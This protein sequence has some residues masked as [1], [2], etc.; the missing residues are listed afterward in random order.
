MTTLESLS[1]NNRRFTDPLRTFFDV[2]TNAVDLVLSADGAHLYVLESG[3]KEVHHFNVAGATGNLSFTPTDLTLSHTG[4]EL[5]VSHS[6]GDVVSTPVVNASD[7]TLTVM[8]FARVFDAANTVGANGGLNLLDKKGA[9]E[10]LLDG[11]IAVQYAAELLL[12]AGR[13][14]ASRDLLTSYQFGD[15]HQDSAA[16]YPFHDIKSR[17]HSVLVLTGGGHIAVSRL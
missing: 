1:Q 2:D 5:Y 14:A 17:G 8:D 15:H 10:S 3:N 16:H 4:A 13:N 6:E 12:G 11:E 7:G 9:S